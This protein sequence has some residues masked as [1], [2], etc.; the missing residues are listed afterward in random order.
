MDTSMDVDGEDP[1]RRA[2][3]KLELR[4]STGVA[5]SSSS[6]IDDRESTFVGD[7]ESTSSRS[8]GSRFVATA[9][10]GSSQSASAD[11]DAD[12]ADDA[13]VDSG[14]DDDDDD[15]NGSKKTNTR[16]R[17]R[18]MPSSVGEQKRKRSG[19]LKRHGRSR[20]I[21]RHR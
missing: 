16:V 19:S 13:V 17:A 18:R 11:V 21:G 14:S 5:R 20:A 12:D 10:F 4:P 9:A 8:S 2:I 6:N 3:D 7:D 15:D 1:I